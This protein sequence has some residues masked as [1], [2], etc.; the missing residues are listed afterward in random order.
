MEHEYVYT[1]M[2]D[3]LDGELAENRRDELEVH[4]RACP[5]CTLEWRAFLAVDALFRQ[6][7]ALS[8]AA[9]FAQRTLARLPSRRAR[10][11][12]I[13]AIYTLLLMAGAVPIMVG[14]W[15]V[16]QLSPIFRQPTLVRSLIGSVDRI[17][18]VTGT[19]LSAALAGAG[20]F[21]L[22]QPAVI[23]WSL[24]LIGVVALWGGVYQQA[25]SPRA[26]RQTQT[27]V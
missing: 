22:Q 16:D 17:L 25:L 19:L 11:W 4:L 5:S 23:G 12:T 27:T 21:V 26:Q 13:S 15:A 9:D 24:V 14:V 8:P 2:M 6:T 10:I 3:A 20:E 7:P 1:L 18:Q